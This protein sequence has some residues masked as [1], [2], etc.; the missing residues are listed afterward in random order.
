MFI[1]LHN[2]LRVTNATVQGHSEKVMGDVKN[3]TTGHGEGKFIV[4]QCFVINLNRN[5]LRSR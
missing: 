3:T 2:T 5:M 4:L 1:L